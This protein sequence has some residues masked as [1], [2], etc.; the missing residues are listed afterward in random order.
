[1]E[2]LKL[3]IED[4]EERIAPDLIIN[5][6]GG[7]GSIMVAE[8]AGDGTVVAG[9]ADAG[10]PGEVKGDPGVQGMWAAH[11]NDNAGDVVAG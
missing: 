10:L 5:P 2:K 9:E 4:L 8:A 11:Q 3:Q 6:M 1:M 7:A